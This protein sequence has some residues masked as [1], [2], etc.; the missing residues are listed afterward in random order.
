MTRR[1]GVLL[2]RQGQYALALLEDASCDVPGCRLEHPTRVEVE[3]DCVSGAA[4]WV[5]LD[6][7][8]LAAGVNPPGIM[9]MTV[10]EP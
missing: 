8:L 6:M 2:V 4:R 10:V 1:P 3:G 9:C 7:L 5:I